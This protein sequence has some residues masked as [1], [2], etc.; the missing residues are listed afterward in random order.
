M[1]IFSDKQPAVR[2]LLYTV[3]TM[4]LGEIVIVHH[5]SLLILHSSNS[6]LKMPFN[7]HRAVS[8]TISFFLLLVSVSLNN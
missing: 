3:A 5:L 1:Q 6:V 2:V 4:I 8:S 7:V